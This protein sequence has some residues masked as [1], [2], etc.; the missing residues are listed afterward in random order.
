MDILKV[1]FVGIGSIAKRHIRNLTAV[2][3]DCGIGLQIDVF[4][5]NSVLEDGVVYLYSTIDAVPKGYDAIFITNPTE[6]HLESLKQFHGKGRNFFIEKPVVSLRQ[7]ADASAFKT[8]EETVY[9]VAAPLRYNAVIKWIKDNVHSDDIIS[10]RSISSSYLPDWRP[11][12]D[13]RETYS[14]NKNVG[15]G[16]SIDPI[17]NI[18]P[19]EDRYHQGIKVLRLAQGK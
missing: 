6:M 7:L 12:Q 14:A 13:Y 9:Y 8:R 2:C 18:L 4:R 11:G 16:V 3:K 19:V 17:H 5:R 10:V 15:G 1:C